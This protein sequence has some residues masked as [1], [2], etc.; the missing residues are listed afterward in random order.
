M[1]TVLRVGRYRLSFFSNE[2]QEAPHV[3]VSAGSDQ[4]KFWLDSVD[5]AF[6]HGFNAH[7]LGEIETII[8]AHL[9]ELL[10]AWYEYFS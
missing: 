10:E 3:H 1:P 8:G 6:N 2:A 9:S 7:E 5:L 4:A